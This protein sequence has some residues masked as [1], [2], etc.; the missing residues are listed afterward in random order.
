MSDNTAELTIFYDGFCPLCV[1]EMTHLRR[2]D[3]QGR[4]RLVDPRPVAC[5]RY[6]R[7]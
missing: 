1:R 7:R 6:K 3:K 5:D 2:A 4:M